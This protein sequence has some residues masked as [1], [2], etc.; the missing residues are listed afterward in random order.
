MELNEKTLD[1]LT[2]KNSDGKFI[3]LEFLNDLRDVLSHYKGK[4]FKLN[5]LMNDL[6]IDNKNDFISLLNNLDIRPVDD[7]YSLSVHDIV[8]LDIFIQNKE[9]YKK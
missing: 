5:E 2:N 6:K 8:A 1:D 9:K 4:Q 3:N 7:L